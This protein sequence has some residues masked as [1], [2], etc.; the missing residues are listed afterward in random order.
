MPDNMTGT[1]GYLPGAEQ[2][3]MNPPQYYPGPTVAGINPMQEQG[4]AAMQ[5]GADATQAQANQMNAAFMGIANNPYMIDPNAGPQVGAGMIGPGPQMQ[6]SQVGMGN[7]VYAGQMDAPGQIGVSSMDYFNNPY[8]DQVVSDALA[9]NNEAF[10]QG[11]MPGLEMDAIGSGMGGS[12]RQGI[13]EGLAMQ[14]LQDTNAETAA[15]MYQ[16][17]YDTGMGYNLDQRSQDIGLQGQNIGNTMAQQQFNIGNNLNAAQFN[18]MDD[19][20]RQMA[21]AGW[22]MDAQAANQAQ[23]G[24]IAAANQAAQ[25]DASQSNAANYFGA[26]S[27]NQKAY[28]QPM[29]YMPS[30]MSGYSNAQMAPGAAMSAIGQQQY[31]QTQAQIDAERDRWAW[32]QQMPMMM[33]EWYGDQ[34]T[35]VMGT[36]PGATVDPLYMGNP[37]APLAGA[38]GGMDWGTGTTP[39]QD[40][41]Q[42]GGIATPPDWSW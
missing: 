12:T 34:V 36:N 27:N 38:I 8:M 28:Y 19:Y 2:I 18:A 22:N 4:W 40:Y 13:S 3:Y 23:W 29:A 30:M 14:G 41:S 24:D 21:N 6:A 31:D 16:G 17:M 32:E 37:A 5:Q 20:N 7:G 42:P 15:S 33:N 39:G 11:V 10:M 25:L 35:G 26:M 1:P 9:A